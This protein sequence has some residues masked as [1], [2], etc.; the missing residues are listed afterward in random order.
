MP[1]SCADEGND[2]YVAGFWRAR[3]HM[4]SSETPQVEARDAFLDL[5]KQ[6]GDYNE[7]EVEAYRTTAYNYLV[8]F[9]AQNDD[10]ATALRYAKEWLKFQPDN[11]TAAYYKSVL[12]Q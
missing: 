11:E 7:D 1:H 8:W 5:L 6:L 9:Y 2:M 12:E 10:N 3:L 4:T